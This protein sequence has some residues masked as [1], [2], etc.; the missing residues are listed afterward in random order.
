MSEFEKPSVPDFIQDFEMPKKEAKP[1]GSRRKPLP[2]PASFKLDEFLN[3]F[4]TRNI[5]EEPV[6]ARLEQRTTSPAGGPPE[7]KSPTKGGERKPQGSVSG[8]QYRKAQQGLA[9]AEMNVGKEALMGV[10][11]RISKMSG[12]SRIASLAALGLKLGVTHSIIDN[13]DDTA[14][15]TLITSS[16]YAGGITG[17]VFAGKKYLDGVDKA[18][19]KSKLYENQVNRFEDAASGDE[20]KIN[21]LKKQHGEEK[22]EEIRKRKNLE[23]KAE[24]IQRTQSVDGKGPLSHEDRVV[25]RGKQLMK[26]GKIGMGIIGIGGALSA[27]HGMKRA[28]DVEDIKS[29]GEKKITLDK[30][31]EKQKN[32]DYGYNNPSMGNIAFELFEQRTGHYKMGDSK[33][34]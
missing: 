32:R 2:P 20:A 12:Q 22:G 15:S 10:R 19:K 14:V 18:Q 26:G 29:D 31:A 4:P 23:T 34:Q 13:D 11:S 30:R 3:A 28:G 6:R 5:F 27:L 9:K 24:R 16:V 8:N 1:R 7:P 33:F 21:E 17:A 25:K